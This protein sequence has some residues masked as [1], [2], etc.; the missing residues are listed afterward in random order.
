MSNTVTACPLDCYDAC[1]IVH[2]DKKLKALKDGH[3]Q[4]FLCPHLN[5]YSKYETIQ[6]PR[7]KGKEIKKDDISYE[8]TALHILKEL[9]D[10]KWFTL[11]AELLSQ[12]IDYNSL[13]MD[14]DKIIFSSTLSTDIKRECNMVIA[15]YAFEMNFSF[16]K[17][18]CFAAMMGTLQGLL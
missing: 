8:S 12:D 13:M 1:V 4:G 7:Y 2:E 18:I 5:H 17:E 15:R 6:T 11:R 3:T 9:K 16:D 14:M 10:N